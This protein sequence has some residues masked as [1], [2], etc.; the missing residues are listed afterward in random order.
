MGVG[1]SRDFPYEF[2]D[3]VASFEGKSLWKLHLG[4]K[5]LDRTPVSVFAFD[6]KKNPTKVVLAHNALKRS[7]TIRHPNVLTFIDGLEVDAANNTG[8]IVTEEITPLE[9]ALKEQEAY[10]GSLS[11]GLY[12]ITKALAFL[13]N[14]C[15]LVHGNVTTSSIFVT[16]SGD[17]K[18]G[19][20]DLV[21]AANDASS[22]LRNHNDI[23]PSQY[24]PP[25]YQKNNWSGV[26]ESPTWAIDA[27]M[28][29]CLIYEVFNGKLTKSEDLK[30]IGK[31]PK[32][33]VSSYQ[34]LLTSSPKTRLNPSK[35]LESPYFGNSYVETCL[36]L[37]QITLKDS[38]EKERFFKKLPKLIDDFP[39]SCCKYKILPHLVNA[40]DF[41]SANSTVISPLL[42]IGTHLSP[43]EYSQTVTPSVVRWFA[44]NDRALRMNLLQN[45]EQFIDHLSPAMISDQ[46]FPHV[47]TGFLDAQSP[48]LREATVK[49]MLLMTP[50]LSEKVISTQM[51]KYL[52]KLQ[53]D[54]EPGIRTNTTIC[55]AKIASHLG[56]ATRKKVLAPAFC[57]AL[58]DPFPR[59]KISG[60]MS[61]QA[62]ETYYNK[63]DCAN[64]IIPAVVL[65]TIDTDKEVRDG[66]F[67][68]IDLFLKKLRKVSETGIEENTDEAKPEATTVL[69]WA[70]GSIQKMYDKKPAAPA[71]A[72]GSGMATVSPSNSGEIGSQKRTSS[73]ESTSPPQTL[74][75]SGS[76]K[77][78]W[79]DDFD[80]DAELKKPAASSKPQTKSATSQVQ[81]QV[82][83]KKKEQEEE[84]GWDNDFDED[85]DDVPKPKA[86][87]G[88]NKQAP[89]KAESDDDDEGWEDF[90]IV[91]PKEPTLTKFEQAKLNKMKKGGSKNA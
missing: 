19:H 68:T 62:T 83:S 80:F 45:L 31:I 30:K 48:A 63:E 5:K 7:K 78:G 82:V 47:A 90:D 32:D 34:Q 51:L 24:K 18:L 49:A 3:A 66:A 67:K 72:Q 42:K 33:L 85:F 4:L 76:A 58:K 53:M 73:F 27:W 25:E 36:F 50:K 6:P 20:M 40:L 71:T 26:E 64:V 21:S 87:S 56:S 17:W 52:A 84:S 35:L 60:L 41:G 44:S 39:I 46:I 69:G 70:L 37:E 1:Q 59:A 12:Q 16:K 91:K 61:F 86:S 28:L 15:N 10:P 65:L 23:V 11:W 8:Y 57:R 89:K 29:A 38:V 74:H 43:E 77:A 13:N 81:T 9:D 14:D 22:T 88:A 2:K 75:T 54:E 55:I 79:D